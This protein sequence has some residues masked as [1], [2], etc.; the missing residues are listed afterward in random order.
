[1]ARLIILGNGFD[2]NYGLPT[3][4]TNDLRPILQ[5]M[6]PIMFS[7]LD[8]LYFDEDIKYWSDFEGHIGQVKSL[9][10]IHDQNRKDLDDLYNVDY[11]QYDLGSEL[12]GD[13]YTA[14][15]NAINEALMNSV[16]LEGT[17]NNEHATDLESLYSYI[18]EGFKEMSL[19]SNK[20]L[21]DNIGSIVDEFEFSSDDYFIT[22]NYTSTLEV[23]NPDICSENIFHIHGSA[24]EDEELIFGNIENKIKNIG[25]DLVELNPYYNLSDKGGSEIPY[26][27][28]LIEAVCIPEESFSEYNDKVDEAIDTLNNRMI[29]PLQKAELI[30]FLT[31]K[32]LTQI[33]VYG[34]SCGEVD[35]EYLE[36]VNEVCSN[37]DWCFSFYRNKALD[38]V[39]KNSMKLSFF[40][41]IDFKESS[42]FKK[43]FRKI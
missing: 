4:Y 41:C 37:P 29:K 34:L 6:N 43:H 35:I 33:Y 1:M 28:E 7:K 11:E 22:F 30:S 15:D 9:E 32:D 31:D 38:P 24:E 12:Y 20:Y 27:D 21:L 18:E 26:F 40:N 13:N 2:R 14:V 23:L 3:D 36:K 25:S 5:R 39:C 10:F 19:N 16:D 42:S 17:F 8:E